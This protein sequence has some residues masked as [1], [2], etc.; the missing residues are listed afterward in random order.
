MGLPD[1]DIE[2]AH[3]RSPASVTSV[4]NNGPSLLALDA[5]AYS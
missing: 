5:T 1:I 4:R 3:R 2:R